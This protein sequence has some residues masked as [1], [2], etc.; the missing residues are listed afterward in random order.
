M[1]GLFSNKEK[2]Q[3]A[4]EELII[5]VYGNPPPAKRAN[6]NRAVSLAN[7]LLMDVVDEHEV[8][9]KGIALNHGPVPYSTHDLALSIALYFF[10][11]PDYV[12]QLSMAQHMA[13]IKVLEWH[14]AGLVVPALVKGFED[15]LYRLYKPS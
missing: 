11:Q 14:Q 7:K 15:V 5:S 12:P 1:F 10:K 4:L 8:S 6:V 9:R 2:P 3:N 13:R